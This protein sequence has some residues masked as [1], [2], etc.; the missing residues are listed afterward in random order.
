MRNMMRRGFVLGILLGFAVSA[1]G[2][3]GLRDRRKDPAGGPT[4]PATRSGDVGTLHRPLAAAEGTIWNTLKHSS[5]LGKSESRGCAGARMGAGQDCGDLGGQLPGPFTGW[6]TCTSSSRGIRIR[7]STTDDPS[8][9]LGKKIDGVPS[10]M[11]LNLT[12]AACPLASHQRCIE[13]IATHEF[14]HALGFAHEQ[15]R[16]DAPAWCRDK[17][18]GSDPNIYMTRYDESSIMNYCSPTY[19]NN[20]NLSQAEHC[21]T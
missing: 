5:L 15:N 14:G 18:Q 9:L 7:I 16:A 1:Y 3:E 2:Q 21:R 6:G 8:S 12:G 4:P 11:H 20:G 17:V 19:D 13:A 10:G